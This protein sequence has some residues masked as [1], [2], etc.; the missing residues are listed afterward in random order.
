MTTSYVLEKQQELKKNK[1]LMRE[2]ERQ[3]IA[4]MEEEQA[5]RKAASD[6]RIQAKLDRIARGES[7]PAAVS[8]S[9]AAPE[10]AAVET[11]A[12]PKVA[13]KKKQPKVEEDAVEEREE[14]EDDQLEHS[15]AEE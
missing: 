10:A 5:L 11:K 1:D 9:I 14:S 8:V 6:A 7:A 3:A 15:Q 2:A 13:S 4:R 12:K